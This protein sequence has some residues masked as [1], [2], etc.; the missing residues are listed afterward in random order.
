MRPA[1]APR[2]GAL[3]LETGRR[4]GARD[5]RAGAV[6]G[7]PRVSLQTHTNT[8]AHEHP[9]SE[10][11]FAPDLAPLSEDAKIGHRHQSERKSALDTERAK[12]H[13]FLIAVS[14]SILALLLTGLG[15]F[16]AGTGA[17]LSGAAAWR[18]V[19]YRRKLDRARAR[20]LGDRP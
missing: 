12:K 2:F 9:F 18:R 11:T 15:A 8:R 6:D 19:S 20:R 16:L 17:A 14:D 3:E 1:P 7:R 4:R 10:Q 5:R 13:A